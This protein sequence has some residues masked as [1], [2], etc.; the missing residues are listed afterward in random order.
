MYTEAHKCAYSGEQHAHKKR[1]TNRGLPTWN[2]LNWKNWKENHWICGCSWNY[3]NFCCPFSGLDELRWNCARRAR[4]PNLYAARIHTWAWVCD[5]SCFT[6]VRI[7]LMSLNI[8]RVQTGTCMPISAHKCAEM[9]CGRASHSAISANLEP[10]RQ[11]LQTRW[12][13]GKNWP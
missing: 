9:F 8:L 3:S 6:N 13:W 10:F 12:F 11:P 1:P 5:C 7:W 2:V 4:A